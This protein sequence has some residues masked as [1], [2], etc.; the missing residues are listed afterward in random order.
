[1]SKHSTTV[2]GLNVPSFNEA[3]VA[4]AKARSGEPVSPELRPLLREVY[5]HLVRRHPDLVA[6]KKSLQELLRFLRDEGR[7][8]A[9]CWT[10]DLFF[11]LSQ[12]WERDWAEQDLPEDF[13]DLLAMMG[14]ALH[15]TVLDRS[16]AENFGCLP[17]Q[18]LER[19]R[20]LRTIP[21]TSQL[22]SP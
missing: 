10:V 8:N 6:L 21:S 3:W 1:L 20:H 2:S 5:T 4:V 19:V 16:I 12:G 15:D 22:E 7:T 11:A 17:E 9:N 14:E 18:L 13:H